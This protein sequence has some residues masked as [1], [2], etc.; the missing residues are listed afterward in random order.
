MSESAAASAAPLPATPAQGRFL[1]SELHSPRVPERVSTDGLEETWKER[2]E[3][4]GIYAFDRSAERHEVFSI[5][6]PPPTVSG[7]LHVGH[8]FSYTHTDTLARF[9]RMRGKA[10]FY[11]MG[12]DDN[13]LPTERR[14]QNYFGVRCDPSLPYDPDFVPPHTGGEGKSIKARDQVPISR[15]NFVE[16]CERLTALDEAQFEALWRHLGL[17]VDW[18]Q[19]YQTI[20]RRARKVAQTAFL[21]NLA[22]GEAYQ[23]QAPGLW[24]V[25]FGTAVAQAEIESREYPG[26]YHR[27]A[28]HVVDPEAAATAAAAGAPIETGPDGTN[29][30]CIETTRP[31]LLAACVALVA[32][33]DDVRY[34]PLF[35]TTVASPV[36]GVEVP[37]LP[38]PAAEMDKGAGIAMC[39]TFGDTTD[40]DWWRDLNLPLRAILRKDGRIETETPQWITTE[41]GR[42]AYAEMAGK[43]TYSAR[44]VMVEALS[45]S[46]E[47]RGEPTKTVRQ[48]N[49][50]EKGDKP[51]E[52]V[53]SR[54]WYIRN[55]G[56]AW[57]NP[58]S[59]KDL[60]AELLERGRELNF[61]PDF[62]RVR[63]ENWV[64]GLNNDWLISRQ[65][66]FGVPFP[67]WYR[68]GAD[69]EVDYDAVITPAESA[70]PVDPSTDVPAGYTE[71]QRGQPG[72][73]VGELDIMDTWAT[74]SLSPQLASGWLTDAD[75]FD[76][77]Y[78]MDLRPQG[79]DI[80]RTWLFTSVVRANLEFGALPWANAGLSG[81]ILDSDHKKMS[82]SKGNVVTPM[83]LLEKYGSDAV[84]YWAAS[85]RLGLDAAFEETQIK[86]GR[87]LAIKLLNASKFALSMGI[88]WD[89]DAATRAAAPAPNLDAAAVTEPIDRAVLA[90]LADVVDQA[91]TAFEGFEHSRALEA[92]ESLFWT[93]CDDYIEL[94]KDRANDFDASH[95]P[96]A[97]R[98][99]RTTLAI[100]VDTFVR[101]FAPFLPFA[102]EEVWSWYRTG[103]VHRAAWPAAAPL[104]EAAGGADA[105]LVARA[106]AALAALRKVKSEAK[107]SQK[108]PILAVTLAVSEQAQPAIELVRADLTEAAKVTGELTL[109]PAADAA[110]APAVQVTAVEL[111]EP[112]AKPAKRG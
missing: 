23:A 69:G 105:E 82:K 26:F 43:T 25:T 101:L 7:S 78:P 8:V 65:R 61:Y 54:Q 107:T 51:L 86:I 52:I 45:A 14:V 6:T 37:V 79:Q 84:R 22:R 40:I 42:R 62:M 32:H 103:S 66:F 24:D 27:L 29:D 70:L 30:V 9:H 59:G 12:W 46:G 97:V 111:G 68:V 90:A 56:K 19:N 17:S 76:R 1:P 83:G 108:T 94:V 64:G 98:S 3:R 50:F 96:A 73:F 10:V 36:F 4:Q 28:F 92:T 87:R 21:R 63:Y 2:W 47:M 100:A 106:G 102:T 72:G 85:A 31:E 18:K 20:G 33:P 34:Q 58:A 91:T 15:R 44:Q 55:G 60:A 80:I 89:A 99:A 67:L 53:T 5:D 11:P 74:S 104:R 16:L 110:D 35:G 38:H 71:A 88:A 41:S 48:T 77:V 109:A 57:T 49:F 81:W 75:L 93:F 95:D 112:P 13:G 39:C